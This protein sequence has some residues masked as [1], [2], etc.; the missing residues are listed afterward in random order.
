MK[1][2]SDTSP[3]F[4]FIFF[5]YS[6][7]FIS[8]SVC[9]VRNKL[10]SFSLC[11]PPHSFHKHFQVWVIKSLKIP[12]KNFPR[13]RNTKWLSVRINVLNIE[14][15]KWDDKA[16]ETLTSG[17]MPW[18]NP[19]P[20]LQLTKGSL[21]KNPS[22]L[23]SKVLTL[24]LLLPSSAR[25]L[26]N[27]L[28]MLSVLTGSCN[29]S[30][31]LLSHARRL[32]RR[33]S[34]SR[35]LAQRARVTTPATQANVCDKPWLKFKLIIFLM[36]VSASR[37]LVVFEMLMEVYFNLNGDVYVLFTT[38]LPRKVNLPHT[39]RNV[40]ISHNIR[41]P[42]PALIFKLVVISLL[43]VFPHIAHPANPTWW[44]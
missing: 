14:K 7:A 33:P 2:G 42:H 6:L 30:N 40:P 21:H 13:T 43:C 17:N 34:R 28:V 25:G 16:W 39:L 9:S 29:G 27:F 36:V 1:P 44:V 4:Y 15:T 23:H 35:W 18:S 19:F 38:D 5:Y 12:L 26:C 3:L 11:V 41:P 10:C 20:I 22:Y 8:L 37:K 32:L 31:S 24:F